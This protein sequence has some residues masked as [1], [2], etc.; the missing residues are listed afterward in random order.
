MS[1][2][3]RHPVRLEKN[4][5]IKHLPLVEGL[6]ARG[7][8]LGGQSDQLKARLVLGPAATAVRVG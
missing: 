7:Q 1:R 4:K 6:S 8:Q 3:P 5:N 2:E